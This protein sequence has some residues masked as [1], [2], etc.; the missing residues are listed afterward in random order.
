MKGLMLHCGGQRKTRE[1]VFSVLVPQATKT[2][3]P[4]SFESFI[5]RIEKQL[6]VEGIR[7]K[8][9]HL[10]L[11]KEGQRLF[12]L[13]ELEFPDFPQHDYGCVLGL[14]NSYDKSFATGVCIGAS[15]FVCDNL[16]FNSAVTWE[17]KHTRGLL[18]DMAWML[19]E[20]VA[21]LPIR[22][23][24]QSKTF[25]QY[26][27]VELDDRQ[28]HH[29]VIEMFDQGALNL[30]DVPKCLKEWREPRHPEFSDGKTAWRLF[31]AATET[32]KGDLWRLPTRTR[33]I[34][35]VL[36]AECND[37]IK[38]THDL[39]GNKDMQTPTSATSPQG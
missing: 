1:E 5:T 9:E 37:V 26:Q 15:V 23:A 12:G 30:L 31:N 20:T 38:Q 22:F 13:M 2:Y 24:E 27:R 32:I 4:L 34:H 39:I 33:A 14:R 19:T 16:S 21:Q 11:A 28:A 25:E 17:R 29:L 18:K 10:A 8:D 7:V 35:D 6:Q 36:D 3:A